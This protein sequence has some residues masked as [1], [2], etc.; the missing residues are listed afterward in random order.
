MMRRAAILTK[1]SHVE[2]VHR[3]FP[4]AAIAEALGSVSDGGD[5]LVGFGTGV[6][7]PPD[8]LSRWRLAYNIHA[9][10]SRFPGRDPHHWAAYEGATSYGATAHVMTERV[11]AGPIV[12]E[13]R[14][15]MPVGAVPSDYL[16]AGE[17][18]ARALLELLAPDMLRGEELPFVAGGWGFKRSRADA[19]R[20]AALCRDDDPDEQARLDMAFGSFREMKWPPRPN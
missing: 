5:V 10:S 20:M 14:V 1:Q 2:A 17:R 3:I 12:G 18:C 4:G 11:D 19:L 8:V 6:I 13:V 16:R 9:A 15:G 7:V